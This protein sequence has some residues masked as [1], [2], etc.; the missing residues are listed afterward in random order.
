VRFGFA[1]D[2]AD[3]QGRPLAARSQ[4]ATPSR[5]AIDAAL[6]AFRGSFMQQPPAFSAKKID[7]QR[8][9]K[10][11]RAA[12][13]PPSRHLLAAADLPPL[14]ASPASPV[15]P[16]PARVTA[17]SIEIVV[18]DADTATLRVHCSAGFYIRSLA[19]DLGERLGVGAHLAALRRTRIGEF[20]VER[21]V[22]LDEVERDP[23]AAV[24]AM[25]PLAD[26]LPGVA[27]VTL[28][29]EG[30]ERALHGRDLG[31][32]DVLGQVSAPTAPSTDPA[33]SF[34]GLAG[35]PLIKLLD[36]TGALVA[37]AEP[38]STGGLLHPRVVL[39]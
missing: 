34:S 36:I 23:R 4:L 21:A 38:T 16:V 28:T 22:P 19:H 7:G 35:Q 30:V 12:R 1:T 9:Y 32:G 33:Q 15:L 14:S 17:H 10:L 2:T 24:A 39:V 20:G 3:A 6:E 31:P 11:A 25:V 8:S 26:M 27:A 29:A 5:A 18:V 37:I 13:L